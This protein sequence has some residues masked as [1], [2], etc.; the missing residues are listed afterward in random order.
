MPQGADLIIWKGYDMDSILY[1]TMITGTWT[2]NI[3]QLQDYG[4]YICGVREMSGCALPFMHDQMRCNISRNNMIKFE[5]ILGPINMCSDNKVY[6]KGMHSY[7]TLCEAFPYI[8]NDMCNGS[9][10]KRTLK[11][12]VRY[13]TE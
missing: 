5:C 11:L 6:I 3:V 2:K 10:K 8:Q 1:T 9:E 12:H 13:D 4:L 7:T